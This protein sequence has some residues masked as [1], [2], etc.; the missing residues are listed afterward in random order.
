MAILEIKSNCTD[1][2]VVHVP[3]W[4]AVIVVLAA[5]SFEW[6]VV[7]IPPAQSYAWEIGWLK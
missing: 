4:Y 3:L 1:Y 6:K 2:K 7:R 5:L